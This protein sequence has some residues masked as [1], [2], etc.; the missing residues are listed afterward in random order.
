VSLDTIGLSKRRTGHAEEAVASHE[1]ARSLQEA[2]VHERPDD[3]G[4]KSSLGGTLNNLGM[5]LAKLGRSEDAAVAYRK[6]IVLQQA[7]LAKAPGVDRYRLFL[8]KHYSNLAKVQVTQG[9]PAEA[10]ASVRESQ[11]HWPA[12]KDQLFDVAC[13][14]AQCVSLVRRDNVVPTAEEEAERRR[15]AEMAMGALRQAVSYGKTD[16]ALIQRE[17]ALDPLRSRVDFRAML[18]DLAF[19]AV[20]FAR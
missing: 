6:A 1:K 2:I 12:T 3:P 13:T 19:P 14:L 5:A 16:L 10:A 8:S 11:R 20:P 4:A 7:A 9:R 18:M 17:P 15:Y